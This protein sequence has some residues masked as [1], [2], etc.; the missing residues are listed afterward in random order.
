[1]D[2]CLYKSEL[3][4]LTSAALISSTSLGRVG[5]ASGS[6]SWELATSRIGTQT[7]PV[8]NDKIIS[9]KGTETKC[10]SIYSKRL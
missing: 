5:T 9:W 4:I 7:F 2:V 3:S 10:V 8:C 1:M 6:N